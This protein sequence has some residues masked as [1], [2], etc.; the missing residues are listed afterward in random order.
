MILAAYPRAGWALAQ[1]IVEVSNRLGLP[2]P[3]MLANAIDFESGH[4]FSPSVKHPASGATGLIQFTGNTA[5]SL[6]TSTDALG[7]MTATD[8]M[9][10]VYRYFQPYIGRLHTQEDVYMAIFQPVAIG[11]GPDYPFNFNASTQAMNPGIYTPRDYTALANKYAKLT[12]TTESLLMAAGTAAAATGVA[13]GVSLGVVFLAAL[14]VV[15]VVGGLAAAG[16][17]PWQSPRRNP[18]GRRGA[19]STRR[20]GRRRV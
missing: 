17:A 3:A 16:R 1:K 7:R 13:M 12:P 5:R 9:E 8:Q 2:D 14:A 15:G 6:G 18:R 10:W 20:S 11:K 4:T 19:R